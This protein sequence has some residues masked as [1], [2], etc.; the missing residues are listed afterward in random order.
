MGQGGVFTLPRMVK[1]RLSVPFTQKLKEKNLNRSI[2]SSQNLVQTDHYDQ[3]L[4]NQL[5]VAF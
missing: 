2:Y 1:V 4:L 5:S 3:R